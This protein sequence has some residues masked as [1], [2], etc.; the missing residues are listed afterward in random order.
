MVLILGLLSYR[1][2]CKN[3]TWEKWIW[4]DQRGGGKGLM[5]GVGLRRDEGRGNCLLLGDNEVLVNM[6]GSR[7]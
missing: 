7:L 1:Q 6:F 4:G 3:Q 5:A 2:Q